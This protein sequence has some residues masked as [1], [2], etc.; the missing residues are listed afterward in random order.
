MLILLQYVNEVD[1]ICVFVDNEEVNTLLFKELQHAHGFIE[2]VVICVDQLRVF[3][4]CN[5]NL[6]PLLRYRNS[7]S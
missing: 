3:A 5:N 1:L 7:M 4:T 6:A 2:I